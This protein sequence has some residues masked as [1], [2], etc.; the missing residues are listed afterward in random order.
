MRLREFRL[1]LALG[2]HQEGVFV[3]KFTPVLPVTNLYE[4]AVPVKFK[5][6]YR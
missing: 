1:E 4:S 2:G 3:I 6:T 5:K